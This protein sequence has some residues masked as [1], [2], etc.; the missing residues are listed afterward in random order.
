[1]GEISNFFTSALEDVDHDRRFF[2]VFFFMTYA[3]N[4]SFLAFEAFRQSSIAGVALSAIFFIPLAVTYIL[5]G[6]DLFTSPGSESA[7]AASYTLPFFGY[8]MLGTGASVFSVATE[9]YLSLVGDLSRGQELLMNLE[10]ATGIETYFLPTL[11]VALFPFVYKGLQH[12]DQLPDSVLLA[13]VISALPASIV[14]GALHGARS[15]LFFFFAG[16]VMLVWVVGLAVGNFKSDLIP[17]VPVSLL[18][19][20]GL[21]RAHNFNAEGISLIE[22]YSVLLSSSGA[23]FWQGV[24]ILTR[25]VLAVLFTVYWFYLVFKSGE[26]FVHEVMQ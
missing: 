2:L 17:F 8:L 21:H 22:F 26:S 6:E 9:S 25:D 13:S 24:I 10:Y 11:A 4:L 20:I 18:S 19:L 14:F 7:L 12:F 16:T 3:L 23:T 1:M 15:P 5:M